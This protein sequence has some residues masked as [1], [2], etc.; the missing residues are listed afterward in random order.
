MMSVQRSFPDIRYPECKNISY[1]NALPD[2]SVII[3]F[4]NEP[5]ALLV[6][7]IWGVINKS[8]SE[9]VREIVLVDDSSDLEYL[10]KPLDD[11]LELLPAKVVRI[12]TKKREGLTRA[13]VIGARNASVLCN[14]YEFISLIE[15]EHENSIVLGRCFDI[16]GRTCRLFGRMAGTNIKSHCQR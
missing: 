12:R 6:R 13:R 5:W 4:H 8:P 3:I 11:Y 14:V 2:A 10:D 1:L 9:L 7:T 16:F 15:F